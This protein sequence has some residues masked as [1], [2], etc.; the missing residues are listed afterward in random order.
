MTNF[1]PLV[2]HVAPAGQKTINW[3]W[4]RGGTAGGWEL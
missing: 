3:C 4:V 1:M 2:Q